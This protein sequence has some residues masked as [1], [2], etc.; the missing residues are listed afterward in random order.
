MAR[1]II[2]QSHRELASR[3]EPKVHPLIATSA[4]LGRHNS[5]RRIRRGYS[6]RQPEVEN[7]RSP[8]IGTGDHSKCTIVFAIRP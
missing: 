4:S 6:D 7:S 8:F 5:N 1:A 2:R 3:K